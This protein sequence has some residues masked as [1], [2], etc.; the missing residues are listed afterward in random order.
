MKSD[1]VVAGVGMTD[2][3]IHEGSTWL[4]MA[5]AAI[6]EAIEDAGIDKSDIEAV[7]STPIGYAVDQEKFIVQR[8]AE[9]ISLT[10]RTMAEVDC[11]G[12][13]SLIAVRLLMNEI[14][15]GRI[16]AGIVFASHFDLTPEKMAAAPQEVIHLIR[17]ANGMYGSYDSRLGILSPMPYY[18]MCI[19]RYMYECGVKP[20][21][22]AQLPVLLRENASKN[23][24]AQYREKITVEDV[25]SSKVLCP[26]I[27]LLE[28]CPVS[29]G[30][31]AVVLAGMSSDHQGGVYI[32][33]YGEAHDD[34][35]FMPSAGDMSRFLSVKESAWEAYRHAGVTPADIDVAEVYGAFAG[36]ELM[37]YEE[38]GFFGRGEAPAAVADGKTSIGGDVAINTS[39]GRLS[40]GHAPYATP[41][42]EIYE[43]T[44]QLRGEAGERQVKNARL[45]MV[46]AEHGMINGSS[47]M[48]LGRS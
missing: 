3:G 19:Q 28:S 11:G 10:C 6:K 15:S 31:A 35:H 45:G 41:L 32:A 12:A 27:H 33:G 44:K 5:V 26:P 9:Y 2:V 1:V 48:I 42:F 43:I 21:D 24:K 23:L 38:L 16:G 20:E 25:L 18:A 34:S 22:I 47:V 39:G 14:A 17:M 30:A 46:H 29:H 40:L 8:L 7:L 36:V 4:E 13:S 37:C